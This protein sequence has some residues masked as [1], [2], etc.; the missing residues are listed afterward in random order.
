[1][2]HAALP[3]CSL[4]TTL[5]IGHDSLVLAGPRGFPV[6]FWIGVAFVALAAAYVVA[7]MILDWRRRAKWSAEEARDVRTDAP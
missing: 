3:I 7:R 4:D 1:M 6:P 2:A 5:G